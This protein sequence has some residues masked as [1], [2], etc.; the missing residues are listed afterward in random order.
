[1][2]RITGERS[3]GFG[4]WA[5]GE[6]SRE[7]NDPLRLYRCHTI[8]NCISTCP[9]GRNPGLAIGGIKGALF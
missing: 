6:R 7:R 2:D 5:A 8:M 4:T 9:K 3:R 1:M